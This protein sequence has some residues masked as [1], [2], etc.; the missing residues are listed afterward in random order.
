MAVSVSDATRIADRRGLARRIVSAMVLAPLVLAAEWAGGTWFEA[1]VAV[2]VAT[3]A[4]EWGAMCRLNPRGWSIRLLVIAVVALAVA[5]SPGLPGSPSIIVGIGALLLIGAISGRAVHKV[6]LGAGALYIAFAG[7]AA[8]G[9]R[10]ADARGDGLV[11]WLMVCTW[12]ADT[13]AF[14][15]GRWLGGPKL[16]PKVSP[17]KTWSGAIGG[18]VTAAVIGGFMAAVLGL[19]GVVLSALSGAAAGVVSVAGDLLESTAKRYFGVKDS[20]RLIPGHGGV[21]DRIDSLLLVLVAAALAYAV[22]WRLA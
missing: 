21:L 14:V 9:L 19:G 10:D 7:A 16:A 6:V 11:V 18:V 13:G 4:W 17:G 22:G 2:V 12:T 8:I 3:A 1:T 5:R 20:G 15:V